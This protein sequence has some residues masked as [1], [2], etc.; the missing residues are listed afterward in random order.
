MQR[1]RVIT[2]FSL[3]VILCAGICL[4]AEDAPRRIPL[5]EF[6]LTAAQNDTEFEAI[7]INEL[8]LK[9]SKDLVIPAR[10]IVLSVRNQY[11][12]ITNQDRNEPEFGVSLSKLFPYTG[13]SVSAE[14]TTYPTFS[15]DVNSS[16][17]GVTLSQSI[18][19]NAFGK[20]TRMLDKIVGLEIDVA[21]HQI[22]EAYEDYLATVMLAYI[23]WY[24]S[25]QK[26]DIAESSY[27]E[28]LKLLD[29]IRE[30]QK[31][32]IALEVDVNKISLQV[33][34]KEESL[35]STKETYDR[36]LNI[37]KTIL[38]YEGDEILAPVNPESFFAYAVSF[39]EDFK[40]FKDNSRTYKILDLLEKR[41]VFEVA[42]DADDLLP[43]INLLAGAEMQGKRDTLFESDNMLYLGVSLDWPVYPNQVERAEY[44][45]SKIAL[46]E[47][48]LS[49]INIHFRLYRDVKNLY[50]SLQQ[51]KTLVEIARKKNVLARSVLEDEAENYMYGKIVLNDFI[52]AVNA[53]DET[54]RSIETRNAQINRLMLER[55]RILDLLVTRHQINER[56]DITIQGGK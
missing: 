22:I 51:E 53:H 7:L 41:G 24:E 6:I 14:Y 11:D 17:M 36:Q 13:T 52:Q 26:L 33:Y 10:D 3:A 40:T 21:R 12:F 4:S 39:D 44:E 20:A 32:K 38:R 30:R 16:A 42:K 25:Y 46:E 47:T 23:N 37:I 18:A 8:K 48:R 9:Y 34:D 54:R 27:K 15:N 56:P 43:S 49:N 19:R 1:L 50:L 55:L 28:N 31:N 45:I 2:F 5:D 35:V 29:N